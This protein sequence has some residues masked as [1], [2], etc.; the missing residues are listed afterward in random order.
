MVVVVVVGGGELS[1]AELRCGW[2]STRGVL[3]E[4][5]AMETMCSRERS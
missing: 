5:E 2:C 4:S 1:L 3:L